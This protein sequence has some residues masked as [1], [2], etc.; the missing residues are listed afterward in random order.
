MDVTGTNDSTGAS[1]FITVEWGTPLMLRFEG[2]SESHRSVIVG[3]ERG[4]YLICR[5]PPLPGLWAKLGNSNHVIVRYLYEGIVYGF[6]CTLL[7]I[8]NE[9]F[10]LLILSYPENIETVKLR[11]HDRITCLIPATMKVD[12]TPLKGAIVDLSKG[13][14]GFAA[15]VSEEALLT[16]IQP[17]KELTIS[18]QIPGLQGEEALKARVVNARRDG[19]R[20]IVGC[21]FPDSDPGSLAR[22]HTFIE[23]LGTLVG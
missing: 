22:V 13:G 11:K 14:C 17:G 6:K 2:F 21:L 7:N 4:A 8:I 10:G 9:P 18:V 16:E 3:M 20:L 15:S 5:T 12:G 19:H 1:E 23:T